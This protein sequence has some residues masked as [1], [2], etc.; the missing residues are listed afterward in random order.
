M[1]E[2]D[3]YQMIL[4]E[5]REAGRREE[6]RKVLLRQGGLKFGTPDES[7]LQTLSRMDDLERLERMAD[8]VLSAESWQ[9][10]LRTP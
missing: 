5:G 2:S 6:V 4:D 8:A 9:E 10:L 3:T 1:R 7:V